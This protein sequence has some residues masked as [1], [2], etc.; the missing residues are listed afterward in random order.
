MHLTELPVEVL[1]EVFSYLDNHTNLNHYTSEHNNSE[2]SEDDGDDQHSISSEDLEDAAVSSVAISVANPRQSLLALSLVSRCF[3]RLVQPRLFAV[4]DQTKDK[5]LP[6]LRHIEEYP[7][8]AMYVRTLRIEPIMRDW[9]WKC[10]GED[11]DFA[12]VS[13]LL[14]KILHQATLVSGE[15]PASLVSDL[16]LK[17]DGVQQEIIAQWL[18]LNLPLV[19]TLNISIPEDWSFSLLTSTVQHDRKLLS[20]LRV[21]RVL[22]SP[23][24]LQKRY[25]LQPTLDLGLAVALLDLKQLNTVVLDTC[26]NFKKHEKLDL[27]VKNV[28]HRRC[29]RVAYQ[30]NRLLAACTQ[31]Q[32]YD[33]EYDGGTA[34]DLSGLSKSKDTLERLSLRV[35]TLALNLLTQCQ[36]LKYVAITAEQF[37][38]RRPGTRQGIHH[39]TRILKPPPHLLAAMLPASLEHLCLSKA[40][41]DAQL[42]WQDQLMV[43][44]KYTARK[45]RNLKLIEVS[46][47]P[48]RQLQEECVLFNLQLATLNNDDS[49][50]FSRAINANS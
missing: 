27:C 15:F 37:D 38:P 16:S 31:L 1:E 2:N 13:L 49:D 34:L 5:T 9:E 11:A 43:V 35:S 6:F 32:S 19:E 17:D 44:V 30:V 45:F 23:P 48:S 33:L 25:G 7:Q 20:R 39:R 50:D 24:S 46:W 36:V 42:M 29:G 8:H 41:G 28:V 18:I 47:R 3:H 40:Y 14:C 4:F 26:I 12:F 22:D 21:L 10:I